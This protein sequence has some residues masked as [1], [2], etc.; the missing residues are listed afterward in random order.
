M[1][2]LEIKKLTNQKSLFYTY[3][4]SLSNHS[5]SL[6]TFINEAKDWGEKIIEVSTNINTLIEEDVD[7]FSVNIYEGDEDE[8]GLTQIKVVVKDNAVILITIG[9]D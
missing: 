1:N 3:T 4:E 8:N 2:N 7:V 5:D 6:K 9:M